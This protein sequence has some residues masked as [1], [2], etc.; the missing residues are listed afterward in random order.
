MRYDLNELKTR[1]NNNENIVEYV[2]SK[3]GAKENTVEHIMLS[4]EC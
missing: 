3:S 2:R 1:Y 4:Y